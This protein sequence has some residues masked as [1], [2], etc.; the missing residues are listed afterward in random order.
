MKSEKRIGFTLIEM[1]VVLLVIAVLA[2]IVFSLVQVAGRLSDKAKTRRTLEMFAHAIEE[3]RAEYGRYPPVTEYSYMDNRYSQPVMYEFPNES[4]LPDP[5][6]LDWAL[7]Q[8]DDTFIHSPEGR[9]FTFGVCSFL[10]KR[11]GGKAEF[12]PRNFKASGKSC[13]QWYRFND[14]PLSDDSPDLERDM[15]AV[16]RFTPYMNP[17]MSGAVIERSLKN[18]VYTN[19]YVTVRDAWENEVHY[20]S[21]PPFES[22][23]LWS[24]GPDGISRGVCGNDACIRGLSSSASFKACERCRDAEK[25][26]MYAGQEGD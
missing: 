19:Q 6:L 12:S 25:D 2:T 23:T 10:M 24:Y 14:R 26:D 4:L 8:T 7:T 13:R 21:K 9:V 20:S 17:I 5:T 3:F 22:Y 18:Q 11:F 15:R 1:M 16:Q